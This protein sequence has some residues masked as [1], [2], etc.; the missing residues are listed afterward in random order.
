DRVIETAVVTR[1]DDMRQAFLTIAD[2]TTVCVSVM[3]RWNIRDAK[4]ALLEVW[5]ASDVLRDSVFGNVSSH[6]RRATWEELTSPDFAVAL[7]KDCRKQAFRY[8]IE[9][10]DVVLSDLCRTRALALLGANPA[11]AVVT[12]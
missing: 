4:K 1:T 6:V 12:P 11:S 10:E 9:I 8:G 7:A 3:V 2:G 5:G